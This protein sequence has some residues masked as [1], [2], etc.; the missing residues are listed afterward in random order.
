MAILNIRFIYARSSCLCVFNLFKLA[1]ILFW[2]EVATL[3][4][5]VANLSVVFDQL[6]H[7]QLPHPP[8]RT[9]LLSGGA[10][11]VHKHVEE[12]LGPPQ[13]LLRYPGIVRLF[14]NLFRRHRTVSKNVVQELDRFAPGVGVFLILWRG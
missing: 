9:T 3:N 6:H 7:W 5:S 10:L 13:S 1:T 12:L 8:A 14:N 11:P 2:S 4:V